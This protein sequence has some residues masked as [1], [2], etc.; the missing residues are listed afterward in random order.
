MT[1]DYK[2]NGTTTLFAA[3]DVATGKVIGECLPRHRATEF[4]RFLKKIDLDTP[5]R[6]DLHLILDNYSTHKTL[7]EALAQA[8]PAVQACTSRRHRVPGSISL[9]GYLPKSPANASAATP[10]TACLNSRPPSSIGSITETHT[11]SPSCGPQRQTASSPS[12]PTR[13]WRLRISKREAYE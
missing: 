2:R 5:A 4:L 9:S 6:L 11:P 12:T 7:R 1:H 3:L 13:D 8:P 10:S